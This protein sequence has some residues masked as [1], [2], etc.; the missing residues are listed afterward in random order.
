MS[1]LTVGLPMFIAIVIVVVSCVCVPRQ[2]RLSS[3]LQQQLVDDKHIHPPSL[4]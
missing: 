3:G 2:S 4:N 1:I